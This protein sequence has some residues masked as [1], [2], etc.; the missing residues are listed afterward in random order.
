MKIL[1]IW[2]LGCIL[3]ELCNLKAAFSDNNDDDTDLFIRIKEFD[4]NQMGKHY[5][6]GFKDLIQRMLCKKKEKS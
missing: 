6:K 4:Y 5:S 1:T 2:A 3:Y